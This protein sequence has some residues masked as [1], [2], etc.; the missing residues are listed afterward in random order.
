MRPIREREEVGKLSA[1]GEKKEKEKRKK[2]NEKK[3]WKVGKTIEE[4]GK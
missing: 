1:G 2:R 3:V 4:K